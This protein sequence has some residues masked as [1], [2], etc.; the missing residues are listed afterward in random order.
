MHTAQYLQE[1]CTEDRKIVSFCAP[2]LSP[3]FDHFALVSPRAHK[4]NFFVRVLVLI[5]Q[6]LGSKVLVSYRRLRFRPLHS[7]AHSNFKI[8]GYWFRN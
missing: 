8:H 2:F 3:S 4:N 5:S 6:T 1:R 7:N